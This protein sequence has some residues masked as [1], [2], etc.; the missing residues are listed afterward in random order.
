MAQR[1]LKG[2]TLLAA[3]V[4]LLAVQVQVIIKGPRWGVGGKGR[5]WLPMDSGLGHAPFLPSGPGP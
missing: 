3:G 5:G 4:L 1:Q 2:S